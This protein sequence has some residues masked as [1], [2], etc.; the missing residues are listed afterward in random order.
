MLVVTQKT[1]SNIWLGKE[2]VYPQG[3]FTSPV[4]PMS[5]ANYRSTAAACGVVVIVAGVH[6]AQKKQES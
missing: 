2:L 6:K 3:K 1:P 5:S 4:L